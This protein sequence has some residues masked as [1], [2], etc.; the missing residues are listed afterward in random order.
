MAH[1]PA[2]QLTISQYITPV[3][4]QDVLDRPALISLSQRLHKVVPATVP[5]MVPQ[6]QTKTKTSSSNLLRRQ[7][8]A[9]RTD[10]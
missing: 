4:D 1:S 6:S 5:P 2:P 7:E 3:L 10:L 8:L 9:L